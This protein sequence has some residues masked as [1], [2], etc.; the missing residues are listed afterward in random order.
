MTYFLCSYWRLLE[1]GNFRWWKK[2]DEYSLWIT[3]ESIIN[4]TWR[5]SFLHFFL[6]KLDAC[7]LN[8][9]IFTIVANN[10]YNQSEEI[11]QDLNN[12]WKL[13]QMETI[14]EIMQM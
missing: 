10:N 9:I 5:E 4:A 8:F 12:L 1:A 13:M 11:I 7:V 3:H 6:W 2:E 14:Y